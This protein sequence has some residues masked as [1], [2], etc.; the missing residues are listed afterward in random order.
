MSLPAAEILANSWTF[1][2]PGYDELFVPRF[3]PWTDDALA[4]L[5]SHVVDLPAG[6]AHVPCCGPGQELPR[7]AQLLGTERPV[8][9]V[10][11]APGMIEFAQKRAAECG[12]HVS[13]VVGDAM[14]AP[15]VLPCTCPV[16][17]LH[18]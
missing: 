17:V 14:M 7:V 15:C 4:I 12:P 2:A 6:A 16:S 1:A 11:L 3:A 9:G 18:L 8:I 10:D 5:S 13:A